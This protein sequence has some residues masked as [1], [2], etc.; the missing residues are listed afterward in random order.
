MIIR[1][2]VI[3]LFAL[4]AGG[5]AARE[6]QLTPGSDLIGEVE[7]VVAVYEDTFVD[8]MRRY[9]VGLEDLRRA[10]PDVDEWLPGE[11]TDRRADAPRA[12][13]RAAPGHRAQYPRVSALLLPG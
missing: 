3:I 13:R 6:Y 10:N 7:I 1:G 9:D 2:A 11:G 5:A 4:A 12:A 8:L